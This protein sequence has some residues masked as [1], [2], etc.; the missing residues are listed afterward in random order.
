[1]P[2]SP[3]FPQAVA[4]SSAFCSCPTHDRIYNTGCGRSPL[5]EPAQQCPHDAFQQGNVP[6]ARS[7]G[8]ETALE[9]EGRLML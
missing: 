1:M 3:S 8:S 7:K 4:K 6:G 9:R 5:Q 2:T